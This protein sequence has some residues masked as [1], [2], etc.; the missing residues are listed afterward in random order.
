MVTGVLKAIVSIPNEVHRARSLKRMTTAF[1]TIEYLKYVEIL[2]RELTII[3]QSTL[4]QLIQSKTNQ[5]TL[6][7]RVKSVVEWVQTYDNLSVIESY[8]TTCASIIVDRCVYCECLCAVYCV[9]CCDFV[10][11]LHSGIACVVSFVCS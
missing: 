9:L 7:D 4:R 8:A 1:P 10:V 3:Q 5:K 11:L 2:S 6:Y